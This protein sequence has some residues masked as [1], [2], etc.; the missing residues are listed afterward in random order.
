MT[1]AYFERAG[2]YVSPLR[3]TDATPSPDESEHLRTYR[4]FVMFAR[5]A[6]ICT[7]AVL[8]FVLYW[9]T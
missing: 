5:A 2:L 3:Q 4:H 1:V 8:A 6:A 7:P 9:T